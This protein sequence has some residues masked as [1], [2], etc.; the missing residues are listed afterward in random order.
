MSDAIKHRTM[1]A[2]AKVIHILRLRSNSLVMYKKQRTAPEI[3]RAKMAVT[4]FIATIPEPANN[5]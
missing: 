3:K 4:A 5:K 1:Q 2:A